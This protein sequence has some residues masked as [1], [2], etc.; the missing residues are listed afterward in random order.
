MEADQTG[1]RRSGAVDKGTAAGPTCGMPV[2]PGVQVGRG[3]PVTQ[4]ASRAQLAP[5]ARRVAA[6]TM[7]CGLG[8]ALLAVAPFIGGRGI[9]GP[10]LLPI[11]PPIRRPPPP[12]PPPHLPPAPT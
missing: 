5:Q 11:R 8:L 9:Q 7:A 1:S 3:S 10:L 4:P 12:P 6:L 2:P